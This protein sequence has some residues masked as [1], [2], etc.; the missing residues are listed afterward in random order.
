ME[1]KIVQKNPCPPRGPVV[2]RMA[3]G[4]VAMVVSV[5]CFIA[6]FASDASGDNLLQLFAPGAYIIDMGQDTQTVANGLKPYGLV[7]QLIIVEGIPVCWAINS[8]KLKDNADFSA[9][10]KKY[11]GGTFIVASERVTP[12]VIDEINSWK[13][14]GVVVD[15]PISNLFWAPIY[16]ELTS[17]PRAILDAQNGQLVTPFYANA[18]VPTTSYVTA[19][20][21]T[22]LTHCGN[23]D[24]LPH[25]DPQNWT[26]ASGYADSLKAFVNNDGYFYVSCHAVSEWETLTGCNFLSNDGLVLWSDH[27]NGTP[28][29]TYAP[30]TAGDPIMQFLGTLDASTQNGSEEIY[31]PKAAGWRSTT[32]VAVY[33]PDDPDVPGLSPGPAAVVAYGR[34]FGTAGMVMVNAGH[35]L[36]QGTVS[37][38]VAAQRAYFNFLLLAGVQKQVLISNA[39]FPAAMAPGATYT[40]SADVSSGVGPYTYIWTCSCGGMFSDS[41]SNPTVFTAPENFNPVSSNLRSPMPAEGSI[42]LPKYILRPLNPTTRSASFRPSPAT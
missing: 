27:G 21:P 41:T 32:T 14:K 36:D 18:E 22:M 15:G 42:S 16:K 20:N 12:A 31:L 10:G 37:S 3:G 19:G 33:D 23:I 38:R 35:A 4:V 11:K 34:A 5:F 1:K 9:D 6:L 8:S 39:L 30:A 17:W 13:A 24:V 7:Y 28:P 29:Y 40:L 2:S 25:A 26:A